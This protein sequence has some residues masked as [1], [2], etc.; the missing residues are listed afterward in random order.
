VDTL[1]ARCDELAVRVERIE[2]LL[3]EVVTAL[4][5]DLV[6][7]RIALERRDPSPGA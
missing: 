4:G 1:G 5:A 3:E 7:V 6:A 2:T